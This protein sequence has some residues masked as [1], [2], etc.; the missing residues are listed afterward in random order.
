MVVLYCFSFSR[1][2]YWKKLRKLGLLIHYLSVFGQQ[3][4]SFW[5]FFTILFSFLRICNHK[6]YWRVPIVHSLQFL[7]DHW[8]GWVILVKLLFQLSFSIIDRLHR[9]YWQDTKKLRI[10]SVYSNAPLN[11]WQIYRFLVALL[12]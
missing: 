1:G 2:R 12:M 6:P 4:S 10:S 9:W 7:N 11:L 5:C 8:K 3:I